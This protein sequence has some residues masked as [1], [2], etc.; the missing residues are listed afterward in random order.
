VTKLDDSQANTLLNLLATACVEPRWAVFVTNNGET[1]TVL[2]G[3]LND[4]L[5]AKIIAALEGQGDD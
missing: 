3:E 4:G 2:A 1:I 5:R